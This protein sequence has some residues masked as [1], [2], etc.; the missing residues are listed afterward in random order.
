MEAITNLFPI[1]P[2]PIFENLSEELYAEI[3]DIV[4]KEYTALTSSDF[5]NYSLFFFLPEDALV[6]YFPALILATYENFDDCRVCI[7]YTVDL[8][9]SDEKFQRRWKKFSLKQRYYIAD[10]IDSIR[11]RFRDRET[12]E[13]FLA[14]I[15]ILRGDDRYWFS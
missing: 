11:S 3:S 6:Y 4:D 14:A 9:V 8:F 5:R 7:E 13:V 10:W 1:T 12:N 2:R 15:D